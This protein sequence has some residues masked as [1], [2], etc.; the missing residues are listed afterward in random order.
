[1]LRRRVRER[2]GAVGRH[3]NQL[4]VV[5]RG[6][7]RVAA[8]G[9]PNAREPVHRRRGAHARGERGARAAARER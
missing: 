2:R 7:H 6:D 4:A 1:L 9:D 5:L 8:V 3:D